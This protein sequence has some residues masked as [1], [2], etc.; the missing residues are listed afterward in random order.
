MAQTR[1][2]EEALASAPIGRLMFKLAV[3]AVA[4]QLINMLYNIVDRIYI[5]H[6][7]QVGQLAL[8]GVGVTFPI[9]ML[10]SAFA[11]FAGM[12]GA[13]L[14]S[15]R[16]GAGD[17]ESAEQILGNSLTMLLCTAAVLT[18]FFSAFKRPILMAFGASNDTIGYAL[19]YI[20]IYLLGT[21]FV[22]LALGLNTF[23][24]AQ[25]KSLIAMCSVLIGAALNIVLDPLFIFV[26]DLGVRG[27]AIATILSQAVSACWVLFFLCSSRSGLRIS[28]A[29]MKPRASVLGK[30]AGL[31]VAPFIMQST[32]SLVTVVLNTGLQTYGGDLYVGSLTIMQS[33]MQMIVMP[34]QGI[35]Q[36]TQPIMSYNYGAGNYQR[37]RSTFKRLLA[38]T[39]TATVCAFLAVLLFPRSLALLFNDDPEL[40]A[41]VGRVM[42]LFFGGIWAFGAQ[43]AC[44]TTF[45]ALGQ[46]KTSLFLALLRKIFLLVPLALVLPRV[47]GSVMGI[48]AS[49]PIADLLA[50][51]T[52]LTLF[53]RR[54][55][56]LL[57]TAGAEDS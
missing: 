13:P 52:T 42:P 48:Y 56:T 31:G 32:E 28:P 50:S 49:E 51:A 12:G 45:M 40:V 54:R 21:L 43:I 41:L 8:T 16:L 4:A 3:P 6:I 36:G 44:Q 46:A 15:I 2:D 53:L 35:T 26:F 20:S 39:L 19:D 5:G 47:T 14:A 38:V 10:I 34:I 7:P 29:N 1:R 57:P 37:V 27:A 23:I 55:K 25:G 33:V 22:Q 9:L 30:I 17:R 18:L 24:S 11:A